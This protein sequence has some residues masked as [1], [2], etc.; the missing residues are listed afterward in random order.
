MDFTAKDE[1]VNFNITSDLKDTSTVVPGTEFNLKANAESNMSTDN[2]GSCTQES[3]RNITYK[4]YVDQN[5]SQ[6]VTVT[7]D[8]K[9][10]SVCHVK[11]ANDA[12]AIEPAVYL[13]YSYIDSEGNVRSNSDNHLSY[14]FTIEDSYYRLDCEGL[15]ET[16]AVG[17]KVVVLQLMWLQCQT[18]NLRL[19][20]IQMIML[21]LI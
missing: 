8:E 2:G 7:T 6:G 4:W 14:C 11:V 17:D 9:D 5:E 20:E 16:L 21:N 12:S 13:T 18:A 3:E 15:P 10:S 19:R 1:I